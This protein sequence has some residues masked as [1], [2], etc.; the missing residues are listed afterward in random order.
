MTRTLLKLLLVH[1]L[2]VGTFLR[3]AEPQNVPIEQLGKTFQLVGQ[4]QEPL[5]DVIRVEGVVVE[6]PIKGNEGGPNLRVQRIQGR[7]IQRDI[8]I[9]LSPYFY[10][11]GQKSVEVSEKGFKEGKA[12]LPKLKVGKTYEFEGYETGEYVGIPDNAFSGAG[13]MLQ[14]TGH[15]FRTRLAVYKG[16]PIEPL[17]FSP[18]DFAG[19]HA[20]L[21][22][23][24]RTRDRQSL[25]Q[26]DGW[27]VV[28]DRKVAWATHVEGK[29]IET[30]GV[31]NPLESLVGAAAGEK[32][33]LLTDGTW[34]LVRLE[35]QLGRVVALRGTACS[36]NN[37]W[38]FD[39]RGT[40]VYVENMSELPGW[41]TENHRRPMVIR[42]TLDKA[43]LPRLDQITLKADRDLKEYFIVRK[44][45]WEPLEALLGPERPI[46]KEK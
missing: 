1:V 22:G 36:L 45:S 11:W 25:M 21:Q 39:Y 26:G 3:A 16:K 15:Y 13:I 44:A 19:R 18:A 32:G 34:R 24:A 4:L 6:G 9:P 37:V 33:F 38:W 42:G 29:Q 27:S 40:D 41:T 8:Q 10:E 35:D 30:Y 2:C 17:R 7:A 43:R 12:P 20:L 46:Q 23:I 14:T 28:V 5:G 31:Y